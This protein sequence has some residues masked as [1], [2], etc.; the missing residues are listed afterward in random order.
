MIVFFVCLGYR[1]LQVYFL[2]L[3]VAVLTTSACL[4][5]SHSYKMNIISICGSCF[6]ICLFDFG[7]GCCRFIFAS[8][9]V[10][11]PMSLS[12]CL[13]AC[14]SVCLSLS[15][16]LP[17]TPTPSP[18]PS[19]PSPISFSCLC[20]SLTHKMN[21][22]STCG[23]HFAV[24]GMWHCRGTDSATTF[25][26]FSTPCTAGCRIVTLWWSRDEKILRSMIAIKCD[27]VTVSLHLV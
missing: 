26:F 6:V 13:S 17:P 7:I 8:F 12:V 21:V 14:L 27:C 16:S 1:I 18:L 22:I 5:V 23:S 9:A 10:L 4:S 20:R 15:L 25:V 3:S 24:L 11:L 2:H 19:L